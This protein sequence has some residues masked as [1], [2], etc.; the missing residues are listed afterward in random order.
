[1]TGGRAETPLKEVVAS[2][3]TTP[4]KPSLGNIHNNLPGVMSLEEW[5]ARRF[6]LLKTRYLML[7]RQ[8]PVV[9]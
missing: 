3:M 7:T 4:G 1:M 6:T 8:T 9:T 2:C 5:Q